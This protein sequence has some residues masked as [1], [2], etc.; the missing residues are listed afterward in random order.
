[1]NK[2]DI[3]KVLNEH[4]WKEEESQVSPIILDLAKTC[5]LEGKYAY[6]RKLYTFS[7]YYLSNNYGYEWVSADESRNMLKWALDMYKKDRHY[8]I[9]K[10][11]EF[12][13]VCKEIKEIFK[14]MRDKSIQNFTN[15][16]LKN[17]FSRIFSL[18][19]RQYGYS[20]IMEGMD[21]LE[22][23]DYLKLLPAVKKEDAPEVIRILST[24]EKLSFLEKEKI[25]LLEFAKAV[26]INENLKKAVI[27]NSIEEIKKFPH[28]F[29]KLQEHAKNY[30]WIQNSFLKAFYLS[31]SYFL[32]LI[33]DLIKAK[34]L[35]TIKN[36]INKFE[37]KHKTAKKE[38]NAV[39]KNYRPDPDAK[40]FFDLVRFFSTFQDDRKESI[41]RLVFSVDKIFDEIEKRFNVEKSESYNYLF[42]EVMA[43]LESGRLVSKDEI[44]KRE[45]IACF[46]Y[47]EGEEIKTIMLYGKDALDVRDF[48]KKQR[49]EIAKKGIIKGFIASIG[50]GEKLIEGKARVVF[51]PVKDTF[52]NGE[53]LVT[54]MTRPEFVPLMKKAKAIITN[55]GGITTHAAIISRE[56]KIP[57]IIGTKIATDILKSGDI[58][59]IDMEKGIVKK[60]R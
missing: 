15:T 12:E 52:N 30:F 34:N 56:L 29:K 43:I 45:H 23:Q 1:M 51:D 58:V 16:Q 41:Q 44:S 6:K 7:A 3:F 11:K 49:E 37:N 53:I 27:S 33:S 18:M 55:E 8:F 19:K 59:E 46:S 60:I 42:D 48:F 38:I 21:L 5:H 13:K 57:C 47:L 17:L 10:Y 28:F 20:L 2:E 39:Y 24:P 9:R 50:N 40:L 54:G 25:A 14:I 26:F 35:E 4:D 36:E 31:E 32:N 22:E